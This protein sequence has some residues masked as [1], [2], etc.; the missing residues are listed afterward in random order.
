MSS[1]RHLMWT[2]VRAAALTVVLA[3][4]WPRAAGAQACCAAT[5]LIAP[6]R[7][8]GVERFAAGL[9]VRGRGVLGSFAADGSYQGAAPGDVDMGQDFFAAARLGVRGQVALLLPV[10]QTR[11]TVPGLSSWGGGIGDLAL[12]GRF[13][14]LLP[15]EHALLPGIAIQ[16]GLTFPTGRAADQAQ[17]TLATDATGIGTYEGTVGFDLQQISGPWFV[18]FDGWIG[19]RVPRSTPSVAQS[20]SLRLTAVLSGGYVFSNDLSAGFFL[21]GWR[22]GPSRDTRSDME[23][24]G[25][26][27]SLT[28]VGVGAIMPLRDRWRLQTT[29]SLDILLSGLGRNQ[30]GGGG[31]S[32]SLARLWG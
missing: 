32:V 1:F 29:L 6:V 30:L 16:A 28:T 15:G 31:L 4:A 20:F 13:T 10:V 22:Q 21:S 23:I 24:S 9:Q 17:D 26:A 5:A 25:S 11:R 12:S 7:L 8:Q 19:K 18:G 3:S 14:L 27:L 2:S